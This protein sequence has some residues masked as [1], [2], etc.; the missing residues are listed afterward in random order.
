METSSYYETEYSCEP[1][2]WFLL[3]WGK[4]K[5]CLAWP[6][7]NPQVSLKADF[8]DW[9]DPHAHQSH[10]PRQREC[11]HSY[12]VL[13]ARALAILS[14]ALQGLVDQCDVFL[15]DVETQEPQATRCASTDAVK[16][17]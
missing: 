14:Q 17:L 11:R 6:E 4:K 9:M 3:V 13:M 2:I 10:S 7:E 12:L 15:I 1:L 5:E 8:T 16:E